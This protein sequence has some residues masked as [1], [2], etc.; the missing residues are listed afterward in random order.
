MQY[1]ERE[2]FINIIINMLIFLLTIDKSNCNILQ[3]IFDPDNAGVNKSIGDIDMRLRKIKVAND[4]L[5]MTK[6]F[7]RDPRLD[8]LPNDFIGSH[9][10]LYLV[11]FHPTHTDSILACAKI[12]YRKPI[13]AKYVQFFDRY[14]VFKK[15]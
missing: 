12:Q 3:T 5:K 15:I 14:Y 2:F 1:I 9:R 11:I 13:I 10:L 8:L 4:I 6:S 7:Y